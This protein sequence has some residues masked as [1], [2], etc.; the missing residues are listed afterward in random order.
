MNITDW[1]KKDKVYEVDEKEE[2]LGKET[3]VLREIVEQMEVDDP[4]VI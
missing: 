3:E 1:V 2:A 4:E